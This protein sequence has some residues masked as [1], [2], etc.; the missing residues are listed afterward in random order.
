M[1]EYNVQIEITLSAFVSN[2][3][4]ST[5][6]PKLLSKYFLPLY[7]I[8]GYSLQTEAPTVQEETYKGRRNT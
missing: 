2:V 6:L 7:H 1:F 5:L 8:L 4:C 3:L